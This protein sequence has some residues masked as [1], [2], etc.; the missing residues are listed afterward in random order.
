[1]HDWQLPSATTAWVLSDGKIGDETQCFGIAEAL[2]LAAC[3]RLVAPRPLYA[4]FMPFGP[5][6]PR[7]RPDRPGSPLAP[8]YPDIA[9]A[10]GRRTVAYLRL[11]KSASR[12]G[13]FTIFVKDPYTGCGT[14]DLIWVPQHDRLRGPNVIVTP[15][16]PHRVSAEALS[17]A[18]QNPDPRLAAL[19]APR[20]ALILGGPSTHHRYSQANE[21]ELASIAQLCA[22]QGLSL[23][24]TGSRRTPPTTLAAI[25]AGLAGAPGHHFIWDG[26]GGNPYMAMLALANFILVTGDSV[27][28]MAEAVATGA[29]VHIYEPSGGH[30]KVTAYINHLI[31]S[32]AAQRWAGKPGHWAYEPI[33]ATPLIAAEIARRYLAWRGAQGMAPRDG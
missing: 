23:M 3:R 32:G 33:N 8:P 15:T 16:P 5:V 9:I 27:N 21:Q 6:D 13:T 10:A 1:M 28:M 22:N 12:G 24:V 19:P 26:S 11:L 30:P 17:K 7:E 4:L 29:P 20:M 2:G 18:R 31:T 25:K 14:A